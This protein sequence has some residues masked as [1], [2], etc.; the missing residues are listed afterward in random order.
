M[1]KKWVVFIAGIGIFM[2]AWFFTASP[3]NTQAN[4]LMALDINQALEA[5]FVIV[6][7]G[8]I[9]NILRLWDFKENLQQ[10]V[11]ASVT[12][13]EN[14]GTVSVQAFELHYA[15]GNLRLLYDFVVL[16]NGRRNFKIREYEGIIREFR[17]GSFEY[18]LVGRGNA[19]DTLLSYRM[20]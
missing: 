13:L 8:Q 9:N 7:G 20:N 3:L 18:V 6:E 10:G 19:R 1:V 2:G 17:N 16:P 11:E 12:I 5:G 4:E 14:P 15:D